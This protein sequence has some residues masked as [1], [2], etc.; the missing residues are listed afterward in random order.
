MRKWQTIVFLSTALLTSLNTTASAQ[1]VD[2]DTEMA[3]PP[4]ASPGLKIEKSQNTLP[5]GK[6]YAPGVRYTT[7]A[8]RVSGWEKTLTDGDPNLRHWNWSA[9]TTYTQSAYGKLPAGAFLDKKKSPGGV[10]VKPVQLPP[11]AFL[12]KTTTPTYEA[13]NTPGPDYVANRTAKTGTGA[14]LIAPQY[15][16]VQ[17]SAPNRTASD[18][19]GRVRY[20]KPVAVAAAE[21]EAK[22]YGGNYTDAKVG[23]SVTVPSPTCDSR[24]VYGKLMRRPK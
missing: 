8:V 12:K 4:P 7:G 14:K 11:G 6:N 20:K 17:T 5:P 16:P 21:P 15:Q 24:H 19:T 1:N 18:V 3:P 23:G 9:V 10:Y 2:D 13:H 22:T